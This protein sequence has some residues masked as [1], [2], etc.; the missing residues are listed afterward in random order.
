RA[1]KDSWR[2][3]DAIGWELDFLKEFTPSM[4]EAAG[5]IFEM[6][7]QVLFL[8]LLNSSKEAIDNRLNNIDQFSIASFEE[9]R[10]WRKS[11]WQAISKIQPAAS[12]M[13]GVNSLRKSS[14]QP[15]ASPARQ[16]SLMTLGLARYVEK[17]SCSSAVM[18]GAVEA[19]WRRNWIWSD[20]AGVKWSGPRL[21]FSPDF[22][23]WVF[24]FSVVSQRAMF[25]A[26]AR[27]TVAALMRNVPA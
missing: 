22:T 10:S 21:P 8:Q 25:C 14:S 11:T 12:L 23:A 26:R 2:A 16:L 17:T 19:R 18:D 13:L 3:G 27:I 6:A 24:A 5:W 1:I 9:F 4:R 7:C 20:G 15:T